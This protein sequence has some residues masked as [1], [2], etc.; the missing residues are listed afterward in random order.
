[1]K[2]LTTI[3]LGVLI[4]VTVACGYSKNNS[5]PPPAQMPAISQLNPTS[6]TH[7]DPTFMLTVNGSNFASNAAVNWNGTAQTTTRVSA[8]Q[9]TIS[10][11]A[12]AV[13]SAGNAQ[14]S[15]TNPATSGIYGTPAQTSAPVAFTIN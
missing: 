1:M 9:L 12:T 15:V 13:A 14:I 8:G 6:T 10:V 4:T 3:L 7:G 2:S 11:P 5:T